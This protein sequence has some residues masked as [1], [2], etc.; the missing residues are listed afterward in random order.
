MMIPSKPA[1]FSSG[2]NLPPE[3]ESWTVFV[4]GDLVTDTHLPPA[5]APVTPVRGPVRTRA[6]LP[7]LSGSTFGFISLRAR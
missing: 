5:G 1:N 4:S 2:P 7:G 6:L 3:L